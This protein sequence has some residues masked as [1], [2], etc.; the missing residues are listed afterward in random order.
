MKGRTVYGKSAV[1]LG[2]PLFVLLPRA[3]G[4]D[5]AGVLLGALEGVGGGGGGMRTLGSVWISNQPSQRWH[6]QRKEYMGVE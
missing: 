6:L 2:I 1:L 4:D 3:G 5:V